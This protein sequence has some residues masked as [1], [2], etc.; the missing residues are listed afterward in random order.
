[1]MLIIESFILT[2]IRWSSETH[3]EIKLN[4]SMVKH[5]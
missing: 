5:I 1:M 4:Q 3:K 2:N